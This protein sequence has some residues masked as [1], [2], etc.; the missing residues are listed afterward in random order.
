MGFL[1][2]G[3]ASNTHV[4]KELTLFEREQA[5]MVS[6]SKIQTLFHCD[7]GFFAC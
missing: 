4:L 1:L 3:M 7:H 5:Y 6:L 2:R